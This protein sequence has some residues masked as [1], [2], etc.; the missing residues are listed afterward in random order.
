MLGLTDGAIDGT[1]LP[2]GTALGTPEGAEL[3]EGTELGLPLLSSDGE[4]LGDFEPDG[5]ELGSVFTLGETLAEGK[6][7]GPELGPELQDGTLLGGVDVLTEGAPLGTLDKEGEEL[8]S[9]FTEGAPLTDGATLGS[10]L[11]LP[12]SEGL[13]EGTSLGCKDGDPLG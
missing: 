2:L 3:V 1:P 5:N 4:L 11:G 7:L 12:L 13:P 6:P 10:V 8:G 9:V